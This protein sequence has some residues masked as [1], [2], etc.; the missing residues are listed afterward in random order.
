MVTSKL[1]HNLSPTKLLINDYGYVHGK[2]TENWFKSSP[3]NNWPVH[4]IHFNWPGSY[5]QIT[6]WP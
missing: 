4:F 2:S 6:T 1:T 5:G 3:V